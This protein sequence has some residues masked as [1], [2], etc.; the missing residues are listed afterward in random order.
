VPSGIYL[1][2]KLKGA[3]AGHEFESTEELLFVIEGVTGS[4]GEAELEFVLD[5]CDGD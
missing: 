2:G 3:L 1:L 5:A 4:H